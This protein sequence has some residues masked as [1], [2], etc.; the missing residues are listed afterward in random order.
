MRP[1][2]ALIAAAALAATAVPALGHTELRAVSPRDGAAVRNLP[3]TV[4]LT[5]AQPLGR[6]RSASI[7]GAAGRPHLA[8]ARIDPRDARRVL[9]TT[10]SPGA[11]RYTV[12][13]AVVAQDGHTITGTSAFRVTGRR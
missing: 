2:L 9:L 7:T 3:A 5:F 6:L 12:R 4:L 11:G 13:W 8:R 10:R 1:R